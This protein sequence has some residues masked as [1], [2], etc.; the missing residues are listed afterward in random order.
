MLE[1]KIEDLLKQ[2]SELK[3]DLSLVDNQKKLL[4]TFKA[5]IELITQ[6]QRDVSEKAA[7]QEK[8]LI[9]KNEFL[10]KFRD[11]HSHAANE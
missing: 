7:E 9:E 2:N 1:A 10:A 4:D 11:G 5:E 3:G 8:E 6:K